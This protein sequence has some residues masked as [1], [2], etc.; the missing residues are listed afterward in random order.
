MKCVRIYILCTQCTQLYIVG[1]RG[2]RGGG[3]VVYRVCL[4]IFLVF[5]VLHIKK[6]VQVIK[7]LTLNI[8]KMS[9][10]TMLKYII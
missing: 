10:V 8:K 2:G 3:G 4:I 7:G 9:S 6:N 1:G 5:S